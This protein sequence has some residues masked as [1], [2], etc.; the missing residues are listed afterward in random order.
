MTKKSVAI[1]VVAFVLL[2]VAYTYLPN[3]NKPV[4]QL[5]RISTLENKI[6]APGYLIKN[7]RLI[8]AEQSGELH[9]L[10]KDGDRVKKE[11]KVASVLQGAVDPG[12]QA[13]LDQIDARLA[14]IKKEATRALPATPPM[15]NGC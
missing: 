8:K 6:S 5:A 4:T 11:A 12:V 2:L 13:Q 3:I 14:E 1:G 9:S 7:E 10:M 15:W